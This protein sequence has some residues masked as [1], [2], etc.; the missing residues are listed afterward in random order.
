MSQYICVLNIV[1]I[2]EQ[3]KL[4]LTLYQAYVSAEFRLLNMTKT[5]LERV[6]KKGPL[7]EGVTKCLKSTLREA[8]QM[9]QC[10][11]CMI[12]GGIWPITGSAELG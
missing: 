3:Q 8:R 1:H 5:C 2:K 10:K 7:F 6:L 9:K 11:Y 12:G 4:K